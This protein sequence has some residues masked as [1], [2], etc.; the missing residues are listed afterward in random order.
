MGGSKDFFD[1]RKKEKCFFISLF[2][3]FIKDFL[4]DDDDD[5]NATLSLEK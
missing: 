1:W 3:K 2:W 4:D 5:E